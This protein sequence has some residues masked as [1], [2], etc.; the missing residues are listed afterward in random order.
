MHL[1]LSVSFRASAVSSQTEFWS[2]LLVVAV[3][4]AAILVYRLA[5]R[6][7]AAMRYYCARKD[8]LPIV[9]ACF[10]V[11][12]ASFILSGRYLMECLK[13]GFDVKNH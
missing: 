5:D 1:P 10:S 12:S 13:K 3:S 7:K 6:S 11:L 9:I 2:T 4:G 8:R